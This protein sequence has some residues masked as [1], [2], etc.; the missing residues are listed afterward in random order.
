MSMIH[1]LDVV[2]SSNIYKEISQSVWLIIV[3]KFKRWR[4]TCIWFKKDLYPTR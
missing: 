4:S 1:G 2:F 3:S